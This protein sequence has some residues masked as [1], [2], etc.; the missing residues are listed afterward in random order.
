MYLGKL[1][2]YQDMTSQEP[3]SIVLEKSKYSTTFQM[4][5]DKLQVCPCVGQASPAKM[6]GVYIENTYFEV[7]TSKDTLK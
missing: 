1:L 4:I 6:E 3:R 5:Q 7:V 2:T